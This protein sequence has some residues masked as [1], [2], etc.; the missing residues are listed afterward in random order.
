M[1]RLTTR[2][3]VVVMSITDAE[4]SIYKALQTDKDKL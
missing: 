4:L 2:Y 1:S 3:L